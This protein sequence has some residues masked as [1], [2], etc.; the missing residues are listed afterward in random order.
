M[1]LRLQS[2]NLMHPESQP[3]KM[4]LGGNVGIIISTAILTTT[5][6]AI[7]TSTITTIS[8]ITTVNLL[9]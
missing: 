2:S 1:V 6:L 3:P 5:I 7:T 9:V 8:I 4:C